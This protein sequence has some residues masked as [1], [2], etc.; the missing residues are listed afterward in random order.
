M[1][2]ERIRGWAWSIANKLIKAGEKKTLERFLMDL[3]SSN[4][5]H[6]FANTIA[7]SMTIFRKSGIGVGEIPFG[8]QFFNSV[9]EF[10]GAKAV[11][12]ATIY[13]ALVT[14]KRR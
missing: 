12:V 7:N 4:L 9:T 6:E 13:N 14:G 2:V 5:P 11:V 10:K 1:D 3:R 8:L